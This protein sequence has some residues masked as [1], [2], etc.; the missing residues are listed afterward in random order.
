MPRARASATPGFCPWG[1]RGPILGNKKGKK[2]AVKITSCII[3]GTKM[4][5]FC[6]I[7][8]N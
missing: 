1:A 3:L 8:K 5:S 6:K 2:S 7:F 4:K